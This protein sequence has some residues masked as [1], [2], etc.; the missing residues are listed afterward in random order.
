MF[1]CEI[2]LLVLVFFSVLHILYVEVRISRS[3]SAGPFDFE[4]TRV[5]CT[6]TTLLAT[7]LQASVIRYL[8]SLVADLNY[9]L[10]LFNF[11]SEDT[12]FTLIITTLNLFNYL[13]CVQVN[14]IEIIKTLTDF[15]HLNEKFKCSYVKVLKYYLLACASYIFHKSFSFI[16]K[17]VHIAICNN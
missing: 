7:F 9:W 3:V 10:P 16:L 6:S 8:G 4:I 12:I 2:W 17:S 14:G 5:N 15:W 1:N 11:L 13:K